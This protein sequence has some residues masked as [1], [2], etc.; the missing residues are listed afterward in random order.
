MLWMIG[1][2]SAGRRHCFIFGVIGTGEEFHPLFR[3]NGAYVEHAGNID[4]RQCV[5]GDGGSPIAHSSTRKSVM[6]NAKTEFLE[7]V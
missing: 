1:L 5:A 7:I 3:R 6:Q 4:S 2:V